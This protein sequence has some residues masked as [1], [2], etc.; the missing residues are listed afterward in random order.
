MPASDFNESQWLA[1]WEAAAAR[2]EALRNERTRT[3]PLSEVID[4]LE[5]AFLSARRLAPPSLTSGLVEQ[6][7]WFMKGAK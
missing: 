7:A 2:M 6:Q 3:V 1:S 5:E 4:A